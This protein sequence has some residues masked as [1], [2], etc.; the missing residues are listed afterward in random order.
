[1]VPVRINKT[2]STEV[3]T[4][5]LLEPFSDTVAVAKECVSFDPQHPTK[6][7][8]YNRVGAVSTCVI[9]PAR[10]AVRG[11]FAQMRP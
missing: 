5:I 9:M 11:I 10:H 4:H 6:T 2:E 1:M 3:T 8:Y 7:G